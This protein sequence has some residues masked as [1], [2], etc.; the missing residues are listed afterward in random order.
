[1]IIDISYA[2]LYNAELNSPAVTT[3]GTIS[4][5]LCTMVSGPGHR[6]FARA[7]MTERAGLLSAAIAEECDDDDDDDD[8]DDLN[9]NRG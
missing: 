5:A 3:A 8:D 4:L 7:A 1:M 2:K 6:A 9:P